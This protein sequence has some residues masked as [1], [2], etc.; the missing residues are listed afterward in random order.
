MFSSRV[1]LIVP[2]GLGDVTKSNDFFKKKIE[3]GKVIFNTKILKLQ[4]FYLYIEFFWTVLW[5]L[6]PFNRI[7]I[8]MGKFGCTQIRTSSSCSS[9]KIFF[10]FNFWVVG[11]SC[12]E[13]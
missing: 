13:V 4:I 3:R 12:P 11:I 5:Y 6:I 7:R 10:F 9:E 2:V 1:A 8:L